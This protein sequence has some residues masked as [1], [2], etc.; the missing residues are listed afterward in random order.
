MIELYGHPFSAFTWKPLIAAYARSVP[1]AFCAID[2]EHPE[3]AARLSQLSPTGQMPG[4][5]DGDREVVESNAVI[6]YLDRIGEA[7]PMIPVDPDAA[8]QARMMA[9]IFDDY[10]A[11]PMQRIVAESFRPDNGKDPLGVAQAHETLDKSYQWLARR[12]GA[13]WAVGDSFTLADCAAAPA[14]F[15]ADWVHPI[16]GGAL[17]EYRARL[18]AHPAVARVVDEA[19]PFR[20][21]F[22]LG[23]PDRD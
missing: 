20:A 16:P 6:E 23:A 12:T 4:L 15:Y 1:F 13:S 21:Y 10:V 2:P 17:G 14:L 22:P 9:D 11:A 19:R 5:V 18:L 8:L 7:A 3:H